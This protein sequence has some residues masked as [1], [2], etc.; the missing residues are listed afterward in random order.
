M[1]RS[2]SLTI[3]M[4]LAL[5]ALLLGG[6]FPAFAQEGGPAAPPADQLQADTASAPASADAAQAATGTAFTYQGN[7]KKSGQPVNTTC[8]FQFSLWDVLTAGAQKGA[9]Q[10]VT[11]EQ[12]Q[13]G[14]FTVQ[15]DFGSQFTGDARW[16]QTA[17]QC[18][19]D[20]GY[21]ALSPRQ[22]LNAVPYALSLRPGAQ[23][24]GA[25]NTTDGIVRATNSGAGAALVGMATSA[26]GVTYGV[27]GNAFSPNGFAVWGYGENGATGVRGVSTANGPGVSGTSATGDGVSGTS[28]KGV[29]VYGKG[30]NGVVGHALGG[31]SSVG[32]VG[33]SEG[34]NIEA[35]AGYFYGK[36]DV[37]GNLSKGG[38]SF[39][40][41]HP[42]DP[43][44]KYLSHSFV[45]S[46]DM[47][48]IYDGIVTTDSQGFATVNL[49]AW[50][51]ALNRDFRYQLTVI[52]LFAQAIVA[53]EIKDNRFLIQT[54]RP[55]IK[56]SWQVTGI[57]HDP[58]AEQN[59]IVVEEDKP[60]AEQGKYLYP[61]AYGRPM[62]EGIAATIVHQASAPAML[63]GNQP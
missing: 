32:V 34:A 11:N 46:P 5:C 38:G 60:A 45:E 62:I 18:A 13:A 33:S 39:K 58:Y 8:S 50:F 12:V 16:L 44:N 30:F 53:E 29:G 55:G 36:V 25:S 17:V 61:A 9:T 2:R 21:V 63:G 40:I 43:L 56:V 26:T 59:R 4:S 57:R 35:W 41:D 31:G 3:T 24:I 14:V 47:K 49:P 20:G 27:L 23:V 48:N 42:L 22:P 19:G 52:G 6:A 51:E 54:D 1:K 15:L 10:T 7:L 37:A 28:T